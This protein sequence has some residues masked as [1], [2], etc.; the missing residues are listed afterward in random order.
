M[1]NNVDFDVWVAGEG[2]GFDFK[3]YGFDVDWPLAS[4]LMA[5]GLTCPALAKGACCGVLL[6]PYWGSLTTTSDQLNHPLP[7]SPRRGGGTVA[8]NHHLALDYELK[9]LQSL[10]RQA[11]CL[12]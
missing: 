1:S 12:I 9:H 8:G 2:L 5:E 4:L 10:P 11:G 7:E 6:L 3:I